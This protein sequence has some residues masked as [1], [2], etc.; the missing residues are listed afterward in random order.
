MS[1]SFH[2]C[3]QDGYRS[4]SREL[5]S[6]GVR[7]RRPAV[8]DLCYKTIVRF[9]FEDLTKHQNETLSWMY[10]V[11]HNGVFHAS[12]DNLCSA[13]ICSSKS[14]INF[15][16]NFT[17]RRMHVSFDRVIHHKYF[18]GCIT[19]IKMPVWHATLKDCCGKRKNFWLGAL[20]SFTTSSLF[21]V[22]RLDWRRTRIEFYKSISK[23]QAEKAHL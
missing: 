21:H 17:N 19:K 10:D 5:V 16:M 1:I 7:G 22:Y 9:E 6:L 20:D 4:T 12:L 3:G 8:G 13:S 11:F 18:E 2:Y 14:S 23:K 15:R